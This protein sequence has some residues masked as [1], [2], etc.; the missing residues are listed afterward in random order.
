MWYYNN[1]LNNIIIKKELPK[2]ELPIKELPKKELIIT[3]IKTKI[4]INNINNI[5]NYDINYDTVTLFLDIFTFVNN[6]KNIKNIINLNVNTEFINYCN[7]YYN[8]I[9][10]ISNLN[11]KNEIIIAIYNL[12]DDYNSKYKKLYNI[13]KEIFTYDFKEP[14]YIIKYLSQIF[15]NMLDEKIDLNL[16]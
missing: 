15:N 16:N 4:N 11:N 3:E 5:I 7:Y 12:E 1:L 9:S 14:I 8:L 10:Y 2:T 13:S 6:F